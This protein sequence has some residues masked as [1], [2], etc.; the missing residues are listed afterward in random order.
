MSNGSLAAFSKRSVELEHSA[1]KSVRANKHSKREITFPLSGLETLIDAFK[2]G[3]GLNFDQ[4]AFPTYPNP[5]P[6]DPAEQ[7][8]LADGSEGTASIP[9]W[10]MIQP[11]RGSNFLIAWDSDGDAFPYGWQN[12]TNLIDTYV[13]AKEENIAFPIVP[14]AETFIHNNYTT[15]PVFFG[16]DANLT[17]TNSTD[18]PIVLYMANSPYSAYTN[19]SFFQ[20]ATSDSQFSDILLNGLNQVTQGNGTIDEEWPACLGCAV[21]DR[22]LAKVNM[23]RTAQCESCFEK[24]CWDGT[25]YDGE[26]GIVDLPLLLDPTLSFAEWNMTHDF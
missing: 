5:Y 17:T 6:E 12:G 23:S 3:F 8:I 24:Y 25:V 26:V 16:C 4:V 9:L 14:P 19:Y 13:R 7:I 2:E 10:P 15:K 1:E 18:S 11:A 20:F 21:I 22:S